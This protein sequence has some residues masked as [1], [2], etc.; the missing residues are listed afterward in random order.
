[1]GFPNCD[2]HFSISVVSTNYVKI[3]VDTW[4]LN[5]HILMLLQTSQRCCILLLS[6]AIQYKT[7][8]KHFTLKL[9][10]DSLVLF[11]FP[12]P[13]L[14]WLKKKKHNKTYH[15]LTIFKCTY[16]S[17]LAMYIHIVVSVYSELFIL[18]IETLYPLKQL[19]F[20]LYLALIITVLFSISMIL[21]TL[22]TYVRSSRF[23][24]VVTCDEIFFLSKA[25]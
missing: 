23:I 9:L 21:I 12:T 1:M 3:L 11:Y 16:S 15:L 10:N 22:D 5:H 18:Y 25:E 19:L 17:L 24:H 14:L 13:F 20:P 8:P 4:Q 6:K 7:L 2:T